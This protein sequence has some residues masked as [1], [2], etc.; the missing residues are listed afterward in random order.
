MQVAQI[1]EAMRPE[2]IRICLQT[3]QFDELKAGLAKLPEFHER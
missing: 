2:H 1:L 3:S